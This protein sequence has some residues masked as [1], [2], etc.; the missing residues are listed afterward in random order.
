MPNIIEKIEVIGATQFKGLSDTPPDYTGEANKI[1]KVAPNEQGLVFEDRTRPEAEIG[2]WQLGAIA[3]SPSAGL[4]TVDNADHDLVTITMFHQLDI[5]GVD[6]EA[7]LAF[8]K[9]G[10][11]RRLVGE[12]GSA[13]YLYEVT[14]ITKSQASPSFLTSIST[15]LSSLVLTYHHWLWVATTRCSLHNSC[16]RVRSQD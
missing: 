10:D 15:M 14:G 6:H 12:V 7:E 1:V 16:R 8:V 5:S 3:S 9:I 2:K 4:W 13:T 11:D